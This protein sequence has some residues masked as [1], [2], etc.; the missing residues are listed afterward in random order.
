MTIIA[1]LPGG[2]LKPD[3]VAD[4]ALGVQLRAYTFDRYKTKRKDARSGRH[5]SRSRSRSRASRRPKRRSRRAARVGDGVVI[6]RDLVNEP[7]NV[8][9][10]EEFAR[11]AG[12]LKQL[13]VAV[14]VLDVKD[15]EEARHERAARRGAG[16][17]S[18][19]AAR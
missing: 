8:L 11:R 19:R 4:L 14:D 17:R 7:A 13:G 18:T 12:S 10:P 2:A 5:R 6:A 1:D 15:D 3:R 9:Y 16:F